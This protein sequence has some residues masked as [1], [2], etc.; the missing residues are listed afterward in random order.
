MQELRIE[1]GSKTNA[2]VIYAVLGQMSDG[3][4]ENSPAVE[5][6][7]RNADVDGTELV[8]N[9]AYPSGFYG[10]SEEQIKDYFAKKIKEVV[11]DEVGNN[12]EG[13][14]RDNTEESCYM[15]DLPV[16][17]CYECYDFLKDRKGHTYGHNKEG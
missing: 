10:K 15:H 4:W 13:W 5:K 3:M 12:K 2:Q 11:Q 8:I 17:V 6:Y 7:W 1:L 14:R 9:T 16:S